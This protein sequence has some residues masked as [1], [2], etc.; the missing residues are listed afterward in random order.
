[1]QRDEP[2]WVVTA[3]DLPTKTAEERHEATR[4]RNYL[5]GLGFSRVQLSVYSKYVVNGAGFMWVA[6]QVGAKVPPQGIVRVIPVSDL[7]WARTLCFEGKTRTPPEPAP[8]QLTL[9]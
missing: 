8:Q 1:M 3:F 7:E 4:Y 5:L 6:K 9:F 2:V